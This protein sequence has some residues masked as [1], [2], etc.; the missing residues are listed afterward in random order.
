[1][2]WFLGWIVRNAS[3]L[4]GL[5]LGYAGSENEDAPTSMRL[6][7]VI[8]ISRGGSG[9]HLSRLSRDLV[10]Q[11]HRVTVAYAHHGIDPAFQRF[12]E[13]RRHD[14]HFVPLELPREIAPVADL[15]NIARL[16]HLIWREGP[17][18][19][20]HGHS[21]KGGAL[22]RV[23]GRLCGI[24]TVYTPHSFVSSSPEVS[25]VESVVYAAIERLLGHL[26]TSRLIAVSEAERDF[27]L[28][29]RL[30][31]ENKVVTI[32]NGVEEEDLL[33]ERSEDAPHPSSQPLTFGTTLRFCPQKAPGLL[34]E[35]FELLTRMLPHLPVRL[36]IAGDGE[37][38]DEVKK[39]VLRGDAG[40]RITFLGWQA[41]VRTVLRRLDVFVLPSLYEGFSYSLLEAMGAGLPVVSTEVFGARETVSRVPGNVLIT[42]GDPG[43]LAEGMRRIVTGAEPDLLRQTLRDIGLENRR[44]VGEH[45][46]QS[47]LSLRTA[48]LYSKLATKRRER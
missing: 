11:G 40:D 22:A 15:R 12:V 36:V 43:D 45:F 46:R 39:Q 30:V 37:L 34:V 21:A 38:F 13:E 3:I 20:V 33:E 5:G 47:E 48:E 10:A 24:P 26:A 31:P 19:V 17:F 32:H 2:E 16:V 18:D 41:D 6:L 42:P 25:R 28:R 9:R 4:I 35:A 23:V 14:I 27:A 1:M 44:Y 8:G 29:L 7:E